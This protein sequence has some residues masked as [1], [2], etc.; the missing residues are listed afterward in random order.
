MAK[1][2]TIPSQ[3]DARKELVEENKPVQK[4]TE[5]VKEGSVPDISHDIPFATLLNPTIF[6]ELKR[7]SYWERMD[8]KEIVNEALSQYLQRFESAR[9]E[10]PQKEL[11]KLM[12]LKI[13]NGRS[14]PGK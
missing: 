3:S 11:D 7:V 12:K 9:K 14:K 1:K 5:L 8:A 13:L 10:L 6:F 4:T 2:F